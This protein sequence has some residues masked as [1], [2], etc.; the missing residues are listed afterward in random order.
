MA[1]ATVT[2]SKGIGHLCR[3][4]RRNLEKKSW[5]NGRILARGGVESEEA[6]RKV[7]LSGKMINHDGTVQGRVLLQEEN[8]AHS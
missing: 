6:Q 7:T 2:Y 5:K 3:R 1:R 8:L 4:V